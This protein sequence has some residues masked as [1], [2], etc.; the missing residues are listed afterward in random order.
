MGVALGVGLKIIR[1]PRRMMSITGWG[2]A[3]AGA[4]NIAWLVSTRAPK[5]RMITNGMASRPATIVRRN[6]WVR[7]LVGRSLAVNACL[8][9]HAHCGLR[10]ASR[11]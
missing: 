11:P 4:P 10:G 3:G 6:G 8:S 7:C 1:P 2:S 9:L 5:V